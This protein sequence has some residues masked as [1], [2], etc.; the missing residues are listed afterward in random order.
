MWYPCMMLDFPITELL[1]DSICTLWRE[2][3]LPP[4]GLRCPHGGPSEGRLCRDH[5]HFPAYRWRAC[6][7]YS[8][9]LTGT[10]FEN[11]RQRPA[12]LVLLV[13]GMAKGEPTP[14]RARELGLSRTQLH[15]L[16]QRLHAHLN[17]TAPTDVMTG[18]ALEADERDQHAGK[19]RT[20]LLTPL[21]RPVAARIS[22]K[23]TA[24]RPTLAHPSAGW[25]RGTRA[26]PGSGAAP[27]RTGAPALH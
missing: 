13:R 17:A 20:P 14:R 24:P 27:R 6:E 26:S 25:H 10:G 9:L 16:R 12:T 11:T 8:T 19:N 7:G 23:D 18:L 1:D 5:G 15:P 22:G 4:D 2:R 3:H 21:I